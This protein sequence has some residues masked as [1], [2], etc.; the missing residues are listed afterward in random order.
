MILA[1]LMR[2]T[3]N[4]HT[5]YPAR[6]L[7]FTET[8]MSV[9]PP[10]ILS[11]IVSHGGGDST[12]LLVQTL[13]AFL[14]QEG[15]GK[16]F[17]IHL[18][19]WCGSSGASSKA[20][21]AIFHSLVRGVSIIESPNTFLGTLP[22]SLTRLD[23]Q[24]ITHVVLVRSGVLPKPACLALL[25]DKIA[26]YGEE[27]ALLTAFGYRLF[28]HET[29]SSPLT[30]L[31]ESVHY[32][33]YCA[34]RN[35]RAV[36]VFTS[37]FCC[38]G[39]TVL[40]SI[41]THKG[42]D[43]TEFDNL[44]CSF[45]VGCHLALPI[46]KICMEKV[47]DTSQLPSLLCTSLVCRAENPSFEKFY[48]YS[49]DS[50]WPRGVSEVY[51]SQEKL[52]AA[53]RNQ[54][55]CQDIWKRGFAGVNML[56]EPASRLDFPAAASCGVRVVRIGA[57]GG[58][59]DL[60]YLLDTS[61]VSAAEDK[62]HLLKVLPRLR[63]SL[64][65]I[66]HYGMKTIITVV[67]LPGSPFF[68]LGD[69]VAMPFWDS[70]DLRMRATKFWGLLAKHL[71][72]LRHL[73]M[74]YDLIN[75]PYTPEDREVGY[76]DETPMAHMDTL[77]DFYRETVHEIRQHDNDTAIILKC[78][79]FA[80]PFAMGILQPIPDA[81]IKYSF[82]C[83]LPPH[84][85]LRREK[86]FPDRKYPGALPKDVNDDLSGKVVID[87]PYLRQLLCDYVVSWQEKHS[88]PSTQILVAEFGI[89]REVPGAQCYLAD[90]V[91][92][93]TECG[94]S[95]LLFSYRDEEWDALDYE[96]GSHRSNLLYRST[97]CDMFLSVARHFR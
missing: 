82:H 55:T 7:N 63:Q 39:V 72:D 64:T 15:L 45:V 89:C 95:W 62:A 24:T 27:E 53:I 85:T 80:V 56:S 52:E 86:H 1:A 25:A 54:E 51:H 73:I 96:L 33:F 3:S 28:P 10:W 69:D 91:D 32:K 68:S 31:K 47:L 40:R 16:R 61:S 46:W 94:W 79:W 92:L 65:E 74:G 57:V 70:R 6:L 71:I 34:S 83:Y 44:W 76:F 12:E 11:V 75:E 81:N 97:S 2:I 5:H 50:N 60:A 58:A 14:A 67:D 84:L 77:N 87:K 21:E 48:Q 66:S 8:L 23:Q 42:V 41:E 49:Y 93:F 30:E 22:Q 78:T 35:D 13:Q 38:L 90:L 19:V 18:S 36:H 17:T 29:V 37:D 88:I 43:V 9:V 4:D 26:E 20:R 59:Q